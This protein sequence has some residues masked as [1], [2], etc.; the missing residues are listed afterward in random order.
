MLVFTVVYIAIV[1]VSVLLVSLDGYDAS[2]TVTSVLAT[3][4]NIGPGLGVV[5]PYGNFASMSVLSKIVLTLDML[6]GRLEIFPMVIL[7]TPSTWLKN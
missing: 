6:I 1:L 7:L 5:G 4:N 2:T 3:I